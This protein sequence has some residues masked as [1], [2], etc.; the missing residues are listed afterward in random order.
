MRK[1]ERDIDSLA[2]QL[3]SMS[4]PAGAQAVTAA[5][6]LSGSSP[7]PSGLGAV[8]NLIHAARSSVEQIAQH[9]DGAPHVNLGSY[10]PLNYWRSVVQ[11]FCGPEHPFQYSQAPHIHEPPEPIP[12]SVWQCTSPL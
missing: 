6:A 9:R 2:G 7:L 8:N 3:R 4:H 1:A 11:P 10:L 12:S 5:A